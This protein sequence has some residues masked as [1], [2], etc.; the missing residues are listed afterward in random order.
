M[1]K[2]FLAFLAISAAVLLTGHAASAATIFVHSN[3]NTV[4]IGDT[5]TVSVMIDSEGTNI[6]AAQATVKFPAGV[7]E[8]ADMDRSG[9]AFNFWLMGP[10][11]SN[12]EG[13][14]KF[15]SGSTS[16]IS[17][18]SLNVLNIRFRVKGG[19]DPQVTLT[20]AAVSA[21]D[22]SGSNV[23]NAM[24]GIRLVSASRNQ[25]GL[26]TP[27]SAS[28]AT[29][30]VNARQEISSEDSASL[31]AYMNR[32]GL[33][34][35]LNPIMDRVSATATLT[36]PQERL[37]SSVFASGNN[38]ALVSG[39]DVSGNVTNTNANNVAT[40]VDENVATSPAVQLK[41]PS[42]REA[43]LPAIGGTNDFQT[44]T[45]AILASVFIG[46]ALFLILLGLIRRRKGE[47]EET[48][49]QPDN[50]VT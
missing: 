24:H 17:G 10:S 45:I 43:T 35:G 28:P 37:T 7:L 5:F 42:A 14:V 48:P 11:V 3:I 44:W 8:V 15:I 50:T 40:T 25:V 6:N 33:Y 32:D 36:N 38:L 19:G 39:R 41:D 29:T 2:R 23:L 16:G 18:S 49:I 26:I 13:T 47:E 22:G 9:S 46:G 27:S 21:S 30:N 20:E 12:S 34:T 4:A 31:F 1:I